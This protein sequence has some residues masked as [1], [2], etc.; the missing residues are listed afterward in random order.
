MFT[1]LSLVL[2]R[3]VLRTM[4]SV[5]LTALVFSG[6]FAW[7]PRVALA[8]EKDSDGDGTADRK[9]TD[10]DN[11]G[12]SD[13]W[14]PKPTSINDGDNDGKPDKLDTDDDGDGTPDR[15]DRAY[16]SARN[17]WRDRSRDRNNNDL[18]DGEELKVK[19]RAFDRDKDGVS[20]VKEMKK[21]LDRKAKDLGVNAA[22]AKTLADYPARV[23]R[24]LPDRWWDV[25]QDAKN[26][27]DSPAHAGANVKYT[28]PSYA[29][30]GGQVSFG[31]DYSGSAGSAYEKKYDTTFFGRHN[32]VAYQSVPQ[33]RGETG[34][35]VYVR[36]SGTMTGVGGKH[37]GGQ[38]GGSWLSG[39]LSGGA[40]GGGGTGGG[41]GQSG[42]GG[43]GG[44][45][46]FSGGGG[47]GGGGG[48]SKC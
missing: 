10:D 2:R 24:A 8:K 45:T 36:P 46:G 37:S 18:T 5:T 26:K 38:S 12:L 42:G 22:K 19:G 6:V 30:V 47:G 33:F 35:V 48:C 21:V 31:A 4:S 14:D 7:G 29:S 3:L 44:G 13:R 27:G 17:A 16:D 34:G 20:D 25:I 15:Q 1:A 23:L 32:T 11:D 39:S 41:G 40:G 9:D 28:P 43:G